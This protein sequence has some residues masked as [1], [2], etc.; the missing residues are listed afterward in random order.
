LILAVDFEEEKFEQI[1][2][3]IFGDPNQNQKRH[4]IGWVA[5]YLSA[6]VDGLSFSASLRVDDNSAF[7]N[8]TTYRFTSSYLIGATDTRLRASYGTGQK[9]PTFTELFGFFPGSFIGNPEL[10]AE[11]TRG[12]D[13]GITQEFLDG[14]QARVGYFKERLTDEIVLAFVPET[15][16]STVENLEGKSRRDGIEME[17]DGYLVDDLQLRLSYTYTRSKQPDESTEVRRPRHMAAANLNY[18]LLDQRANM[19]LNVSYT[20]AQDDVIFLPPLFAPEVV[21]LSDYL[22]VDLSGSYSLTDR[23]AF[24]LRVENLFDEDYTTV[25]GYRTPG[26]GVYAGVRLSLSR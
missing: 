25:V 19:N 10:Q 22:L 14:W 1:G 2:Q 20:G 13:I 17:V 12:F 26:R 16:L 8:V 23:L 6:P 7:K 4:N 18:S 9:A 15:F 11:Q 24:N 3:V 21:Q 5:E